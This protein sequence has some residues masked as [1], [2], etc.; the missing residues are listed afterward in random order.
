[1]STDVPGPGPACDCLCALGGSPS[2]DALARPFSRVRKCRMRLLP[3]R[4]GPYSPPHV[5]TYLQMSE[6]SRD[7]NSAAVISRPS[8]SILTRHMYSTTD[9]P[10]QVLKI[11][12]PSTSTLVRSYPLP[13]GDRQA[14]S[15]LWIASCL[16]TRHECGI[17][18]QLD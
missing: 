6:G 2:F 5:G 13:I 18:P 12:V 17:V 14:S 3:P 11:A 1:M 7:G 8:L 9:D 15:I 10:C 4:L 16:L